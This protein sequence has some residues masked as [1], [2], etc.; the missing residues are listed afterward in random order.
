[1]AY[2][3]I[4]VHV[5]DHVA[6]ITLN[7]PDALNALNGQLLGELAKALKSADENDKVRCIV[8]TGAGDTAFSAGGDIATFA[9][10]DDVAAYRRRLRLVYDAFHSVEIPLPGLIAHTQVFHLQ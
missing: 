1:M 8:L 6:Q 5:E 2:E 4:I 7:R 9:V 10:M 3:T